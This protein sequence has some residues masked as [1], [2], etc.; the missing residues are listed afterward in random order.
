VAFLFAS[1]EGGIVLPQMVLFDTNGL[2]VDQFLAISD[3]SRAD[4]F[5][6]RLTG[7]GVIGFTTNA[8][9]VYA[10]SDYAEV[11]VRRS[12]GALGEQEVRVHTAT[13]PNG[14]AQDGA[15]FKKVETNL[16]WAS[17]EMGDKWVRIP[18]QGDALDFGASL[19]GQVF[20]AVLSSAATNMTARL[21]ITNQAITLQGS[22]SSTGDWK[23]D[24]SG[25]WRV[26]ENTGGQASS[27]TWGA[28][29]GGWLTFAWHKI[30]GGGTLAAE[31]PG[32]VTN[33]ATGEM[34]NRV[35]VAEGTNVVWSLTN[36]TATVK[37]LDWTP[38]EVQLIAPTNGAVVSVATNITFSWAVQPGVTSRLYYAQTQV[39]EPQLNY[40][41][42]DVTNHVPYTNAVSGIVT[43]YVEMEIRGDLQTVARV[44]GP[45]WSFNFQTQM[46]IPAPPFPTASA[47]VSWGIVLH[48]HVPMSVST[49]ADLENEHAT[50]RYTAKGLPSGLKIDASTGVISGTPK[51]AG[52]SL[53]TVKAT[54]DGTT[55]V[56]ELAI[57]VLACPAFALGEFQGVVLDE[58]G[59]VR[60]TLALKVSASGAVVGRLEGG[61]RSQSL[62]GAWVDGSELV[63]TIRM[64]VSRA[65]VM[66]LTLTPEG[67]EG[68]TVEGWRVL[69][70]P[71]LSQEA[72]QPFAD[73]YAVVLRTDMVDTPGAPAGCGYLT[74][75]VTP[76]TRSVKYAGVLADGTSV[77]GSAKI[78]AGDEA[79]AALFPLYKGL[80]A[81]RGEVSGV[82][83]S[84]PD[85]SVALSQGGWLNPGG[86]RSRQGSRVPFD[87]ALD[88]A[89]AR[90]AQ[91]SDW[92]VLDG[93]WLTADGR[94][95]ATLS[96]ARGKPVA[97]TAGVTFSLTKRSGV[98][99]GR[100]TDE[101][102]ITRAFRGVYMP[103][104]LYGAGFY[105]CPD[106]GDG[107]GPCSLP[108]ELE[109]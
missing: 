4:D 85:G 30:D 92:R 32:V 18:L 7:P 2:K 91:P 26:V 102:D 84:V 103:A 52:L 34:T 16:V 96:E 11:A 58:T 55:A 75:T 46:D 43:W 88:G 77:S 67:V 94:P 72:A 105:L 45:E 1:G 78:V 73:S 87:A 95:F 49:A 23:Y 44:M 104:L 51:R 50:R 80:Y 98:F 106:G 57:E 56:I 48:Q 21:G 6:D 8:L 33:T 107:L 15:L 3:L 14:P 12:G 29:E 76:R 36:C 70:R 74:Y 37:L 13:E 19:T 99:T 61:G 89:G 97:Q 100:F 39:P 83:A 40:V 62:R 42:G 25:V 68:A 101:T 20:Y 24:G 53:A 79:G 27:L 38:A 63:R 69:A 10:G 93:A 47:M 86:G 28:R 65:E 71:I 5:I 35:A 64:T 22:V 66:A 54:G 41:G 108:I 81:R 109:Q 59:R 31:L 9:A 60:G 82:V 17:G 90:Y